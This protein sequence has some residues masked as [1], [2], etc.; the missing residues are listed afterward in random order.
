LGFVDGA[1]K[2]AS[3][4][5]HRIAQCVETTVTMQKKIRSNVM[6]ANAVEMWLRDLGRACRGQLLDAV[7][8]V[9]V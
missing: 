7:D 9:V 6:A 5:P 1:G 2:D 4:K 3:A 8:D